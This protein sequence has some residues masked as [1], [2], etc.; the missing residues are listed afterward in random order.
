MGHGIYIERIAFV[1]TQ[2]QGHIEGHHNH[3]SVSDNI[4]SIDSD[5]PLV[6]TNMTNIFNLCKQKSFALKVNKKR[7]LMSKLDRSKQ[8]REPALTYSNNNAIFTLFEIN[9]FRK[10]MTLTTL[11]RM[12]FYNSR[13]HSFQGFAFSFLHHD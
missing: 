4:N 2:K 10:M 5:M 1:K 13:K 6:L 11:S 12:Y 8:Q 3:R 7:T 9:P